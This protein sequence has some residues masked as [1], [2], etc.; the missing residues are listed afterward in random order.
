MML[1]PKAIYRFSAN[2]VAI[3]TAFFIEL[4]QITLKFVWK[5]KEPEWPKQYGESRSDLE[6]M[7]SLTLDYTTNQQ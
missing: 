1:L 3:L 7:C 2:P 5:K 6:E 4:E